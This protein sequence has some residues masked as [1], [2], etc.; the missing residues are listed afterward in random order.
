MASTT[1]LGK[2]KQT[3]GYSTKCNISAGRQDGDLHRYTVIINSVFRF[4]CYFNTI[5]IWSSSS[6]VLDIFLQ[7]LTLQKFDSYFGSSMEW[8]DFC[9]RGIV[10]WLLLLFLVLIHMSQVHTRSANG[11]PKFSKFTRLRK[12]NV[13]PAYS[14]L[15]L[16]LARTTHTLLTGPLPTTF[17]HRDLNNVPDCSQ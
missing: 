17:H 2:S 5:S 8:S 6:P 3:R 16:G 1:L 13:F 9:L 11:Y 15:F 7:E 14:K 12:C 4:Q 10:F